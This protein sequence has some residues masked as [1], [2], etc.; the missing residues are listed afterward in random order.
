MRVEA[1]LNLLIYKIV[2]YCYN[3]IYSFKM[4][5]YV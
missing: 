5:E 1:D 3:Y 4:E 2:F